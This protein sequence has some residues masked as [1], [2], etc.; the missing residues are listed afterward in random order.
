MTICLQ[1]KYTFVV[2]Y[3]VY[4][5]NKLK[6]TYIKFQC[7]NDNLLINYTSLYIY[8]RHLQWNMNINLNWDNS[9]LFEDFMVC[10]DTPSYGWVCGWLDG[11]LV[12]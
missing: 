9:I 4:R 7:I 10:G 8:T 2:K 3:T 11:W 12:R 6:D 5:N 1:I